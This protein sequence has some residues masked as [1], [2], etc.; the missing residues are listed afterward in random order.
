M[1]KSICLISPGHV[2]F[3]PRLVKEA[4]ALAHAGYDVHVIAANNLANVRRLDRPILASAAWTYELVGGASDFAALARRA[5][6]KFANILVGRGVPSLTLA[7]WGHHA[8]THLL[9]QRAIDAKADLYIAHYVAALP[10]AYHAA[11][12]HDGKWGFDAE[13]F[14]SGEFTPPQQNSSAARAVRMIEGAYLPHSDHLTAASPGIARACR[15]AY[16]VDNPIVVLNVFPRA[17]APERPS[18]AGVEAPGPSIYWFSQ[19]I[20]RE[21]GLECALEAIAQSRS[22]PHLY[23]RGNLQ[24]GFRPY[25]EGLAERLRLV[26]RVHVLPTAPGV[27]MERLAAR[28]DLG[29]VGETGHTENRA[30]ALTNK[31]FSYLLA[32]VPVVASDIPAHRAVA[33]DCP[34]VLLYGV[35]RAA[36]LAARI[37]SLLLDPGALAEARLQAWSAGQ[38][39][40]NWDME[41]AKLV[42]AVE[43]QIGPP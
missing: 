16:G 3:N 18:P 13:D 21:R 37:D 11:Q 43:K 12:R 26:D 35:D 8:L 1:A 2:A 29:F 27:E 22:R 4:D 28:Y 31:M 39:R 32:G 24:A 20:G 30:I 15:D 5:V 33:Q 14:H 40:Y 17:Q 23:L 38:S 25:F 41:Q 9:K 6:S 7:E 10:A 42:H 34:A 36:E 19:T